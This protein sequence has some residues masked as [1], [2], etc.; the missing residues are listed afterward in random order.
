M[1]VRIRQRGNVSVVD[2]HG[3]IT[4][5]GNDVALKEA[6]RT[7]LDAGKREILLNIEQ[8]SYMDSAGLGELAAC[9]KR[10]AV[11]RGALKLLNPSRKIADLLKITKADDVFETFVDEDLALASFR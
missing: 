9:H 3:E 11:A 1:K 5:G 7:L 4:I 8:V 6:V 2:V 10:V